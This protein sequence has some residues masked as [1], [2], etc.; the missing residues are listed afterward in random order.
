M[1]WENDYNRQPGPWTGGHAGGV[2]P[3]LEHEI[4]EHA[5][6]YAELHPDP[7][8][9]T[10]LTSIARRVVARLRDTRGRGRHPAEGVTS[11]EDVWAREEAL[12]RAKNEGEP[13][14]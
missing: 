9:P 1:N 11:S 8:T 13:H 7:P 5:G 4:E 2:D 14:G 3:G 10:S 6:H 12:Y